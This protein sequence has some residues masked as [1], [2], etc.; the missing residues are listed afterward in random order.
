MSELQ[1]DVAIVGAGV[2]GLAAARLLTSQGL[3]CCLLEASNA[4]GGR[5]RTVRRAGWQIPIELGAEFVH[6]RPAPTL[7]IGGGI[8]LIPVPERRMMAAPDPQ[9]MHDTWRHFAAALDGARD[10]PRGESMAAYLERARLSRP[11][12]QLVQMMV[13]GYHAAPLNDVS[14]LAVAEDAA[15]AGAHFTQ[16]RPAHG[17]D[18]VLVELE[19]GLEQRLCRIQLGA[20][21]ERL[22]WS[23]GK[24][25]VHANSPEGPL[26]LSATCCLVTTSIGVLQA[27][28]GR[29]GIAFEPRPPEFSSALSLLAMGNA[30]RV[31]MRFE[32]APW[33]D[34]E[35]ATAATFLQVP[36]AQFP[37]LWRE[38][39]AS[40]QTQITAWAGGPRA[41]AASKLETPALIEAALESL[42]Q[43]TQSDVSAC[44][45]ALIEAHHHDFNGD[46]LTLGAYSYVR[47][48]GESAARALGEPWKNTVF[49]AGE[50][51]DLQYPGTVAG[52]LGSGEHAARKLLLSLRGE[53]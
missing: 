36:L 29:G 45:S 21:V 42:A 13:E 35:P 17:Y 51:L 34:I 4:I 18:A 52:A 41:R 31:V 10:A 38:T 25:A 8:E 9:P 3:R 32:R 30:L 46:P 44:R 11:D 15:N 6:G 39:H 48:G 40:G 2:A 1:A 43:G 24:V 47:P 33:V 49:F 37:T 27:P 26:R 7:S 19:A 16:Y 22:A 28:A 23:P 12:Q 50:A 53:P 14:A 5:V 20:R